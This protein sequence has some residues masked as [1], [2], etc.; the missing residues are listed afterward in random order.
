MGL[1]LFMNGIMVFFLI[2]YSS[3]SPKILNRNRNTRP[4]CAVFLY[5]IQSSFQT[6]GEHI[7]VTAYLIA[8]LWLL[9]THSH[10]SRIQQEKS[11]SRGLARAGPS[12]F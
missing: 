9:R 10:I 12:L 11:S 8:A 2:P 3:S 5:L 4:A 7:V 1:T 6:L